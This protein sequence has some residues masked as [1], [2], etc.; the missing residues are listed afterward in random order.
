MILIN[1]QLEQLTETFAVSKDKLQ[2]DS[3]EERIEMTA[4]WQ[5]V[6][7]S[8]DERMIKHKEKIITRRGQAKTDQKNCEQWYQ[9]Q[10]KERGIDQQ[11]LNTLESQQNEL[12]TKITNTEQLRDEVLDY[13]FWYQQKWLER[14]PEQQ[15]QLTKD[16]TRLEKL[17][18]QFSIQEQ[19]YKAERTNTQKE[20]KQAQINFTQAESLY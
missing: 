2:Q 6:I 14:K 11:E 15:Q 19:H 1:I 17:T 9:Q 13:N 12:Q 7:Q 4:H 20:K 16:R 3:A 18:Q 8:I 10:C 5:E